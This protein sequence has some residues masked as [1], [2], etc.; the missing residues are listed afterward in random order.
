MSEQLSVKIP[1]DVELEDKLV[2]GLTGRQLVI[3]GGAGLVLYLVFAATSGLVPLWVFA[4]FAAPVAAVAVALALGRRDG[5][6]FD[7][8]ILAALAH[9]WRTRPHPASDQPEPSQPETGRARRGRVSGWVAGLV[10]VRQPLTAPQVPAR[11]VAAAGALGVVDLGRA[12]LGC[13]AVCST[14]SLALSTPGEQEALVATFG[15]YLHSLSAPIQLLIRARPLQLDAQI[16][17]LDVAAT[18]LPPALAAAAADHADYLYR[19]SIEH[20][21]LCRQVILI[22]REPAPAGPRRT[23]DTLVKADRAAVIRLTRR[24]AEAG[25]LLAPAGITLTVLDAAQA[26]AVLDSA[27]FP[28]HGPD[29]AD[30][31]VSADPAPAHPADPNQYGHPAAGQGA[32]EEHAAPA[33]SPASR[34]ADGPDTQGEGTDVPEAEAGPARGDL[35]F[36][37]WRS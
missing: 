32:G 22:V 16:R 28:H 15:R 2:F 24:L 37:G 33:H 34:T 35:S 29:W 21:L 27:C 36:W 13:L 18:S 19:L 30:S 14:V 31:A 9:L 1:A 11:E 17:A 7:R 25:E 26:A 5:V 6:S 20:E 4:G 10:G 12:G 23:G 8:W 3:L